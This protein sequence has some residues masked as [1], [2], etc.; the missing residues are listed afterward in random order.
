MFDIGFWE[1]AV[2]GVIAL[3]VIGPERL[4]KLAYTA[5]LWF[6]KARRFVMSVK[7][8]IEQEVKAEELKQIMKKQAESSGIHEIIEET[9]DA[10]D[11]VDKSDYLVKAEKPA[12][13]KAKAIE[14]PAEDKSTPIDKP[15]N[16]KIKQDDG[17]KS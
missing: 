2:I 12:A 4:P 10:L 3:L 17:G 13:D 1:L 11:E 6:G 14:E 7:A 9:R 8:D 15:A 5:G 16:D